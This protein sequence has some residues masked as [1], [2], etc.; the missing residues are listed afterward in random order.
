MPAGYLRALH[1]RTGI[2]VTRWPGRRHACYVSAFATWSCSTSAWRAPAARRP[3]GALAEW[4]WPPGES[5]LAPLP[6]NDEHRHVSH[7][8]PVWPLHEIT[9][10]GTPR[11]SRRR[12]CGRCDGGAPRTTRPTG[13][14]TGRSRR[15]ACGTRNWPAVSAICG[16]GFFFRS[17]MSSHY[18]GRSV[19]NADAACALPGV[20]AE[21]LADSVPGTIG[22][23]DLLPSVPDFLPAGRARGIR[24]LAGV[25]VDDLRWDLRTGR[26][27]AVLLSSCGHRADVGFWRAP[28]RRVTLR[29]GEPVRLQAGGS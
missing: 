8:Y 7:L 11:G 25:L 18:P 29:A 16:R 13:T 9:A 3:D 10:A 5:G 6:G 24:T 22:R 2:A 17:L 19:Y 21:M 14:S 28:P 1:Y 4:A 15:R 27:E 20:L 26:A 12:P 23:I